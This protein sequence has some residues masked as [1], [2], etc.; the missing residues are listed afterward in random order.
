MK[1]KVLNVGKLKN[2]QPEHAGKL[3]I[4]PEAENFGEG[5]LEFQFTDNV[6]ISIYLHV[7]ISIYQR[8]NFNLLTC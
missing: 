5:V 6:E 3:N 4:P 8:G 1:K 2:A 7:E